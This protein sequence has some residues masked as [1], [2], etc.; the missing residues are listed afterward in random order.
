MLDITEKADME[1]QYGSYADHINRS[2]FWKL[3]EVLFSRHAAS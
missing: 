2:L 3:W 1:N